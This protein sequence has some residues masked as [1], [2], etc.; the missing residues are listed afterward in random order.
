[1]LIFKGSLIVS[2]IKEFAAFVKNIKYTTVEWYPVDMDIEN[3]HENTYF[4]HF[5]VKM[6]LMGLPEINDHAIS[7]SYYCVL[8]FGNNPFRI[9]EEINDKQGKKKCEQSGQF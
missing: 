3:G 2:R 9:S 4:Q 7:G 6:L 8:I 1:L 5:F